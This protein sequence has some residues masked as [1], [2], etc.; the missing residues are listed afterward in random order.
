LY[1]AV[2]FHTM[3]ISNRPAPKEIDNELTSLDVIKR[4][5]D[6]GASVNA[7]LK[8]QPPY[9]TKLDRG[10]DT[11]LTTGTTPL[12]RAAKAGD[13]LVVGLLLSKGADPTLTT[14]NGINPMMAAAG[15]GTREED[16]TGRHKTESDVIET[17]K[18][19]LD[20]GVDINAVESSGKS[21][22]YGAALMGYNQVIQFL[23]EHGAK[24]D[25]KDKQGQSPIDA[26]TGATG[27]AGFDGASGIARESTAALIRKLMGQ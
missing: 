13:F 8:T 9:R 25:I 7:Q 1:A 5:L 10:D 3:P 27:G 16:T 21:A 11:M 15:I 20:A 26:A 4:L 23:A 22:I 18:L 12:L 2:D 19:C 24:L 14:R 6:R 17:I